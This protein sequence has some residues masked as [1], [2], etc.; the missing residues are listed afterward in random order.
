MQSD[1]TAD[2]LATILETVLA[3]DDEIIR[4][5]SRLTHAEAVAREA[6]ARAR[7]LES[8]LDARVADL[9]A[10]LMRVEVPL[11]REHYRP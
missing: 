5:T 4:L 6:D 7:R 2:D 9:E 11:I 1:F 10:R 3:Q 8:K